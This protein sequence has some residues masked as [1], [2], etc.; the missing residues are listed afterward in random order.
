VPNTPSAFGQLVRAERH[1]R[2]DLHSEVTALEHA[3]ALPRA[4]RVHDAATEVGL[5]MLD[6][7]VSARQLHEHVLHDVLGDRCASRQ[8]IGEP[9]EPV[10]MQSEQDV[11]IGWRRR[12]VRR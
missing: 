6:R 9:D 3:P 11:E 1:G 10:A 4:H 8:Q 5:W 12:P 7:P 2:C